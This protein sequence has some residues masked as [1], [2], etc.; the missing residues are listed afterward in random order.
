MEYLK[1]FKRIPPKI[2][3][4][5]DRIIYPGIN[6]VAFS[7]EKEYADFVNSMAYQNNRKAGAIIE[8]KVG[9]FKP[10]QVLNIPSAVEIIVDKSADELEKVLTGSKSKHEKRVVVAPKEKPKK[11]K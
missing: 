3:K 1:Y 9:D 6:K 10:D 5:S 11:G 2:T 7:S 4:I 8:L